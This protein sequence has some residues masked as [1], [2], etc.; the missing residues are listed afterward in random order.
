MHY[1]V[2]TFF[3]SRGVPGIRKLSSDKYKGSFKMLKQSGMGEPSLRARLH[4]R[5]VH[6]W[7]GECF[8][9]DCEK[10]TFFFAS[11]SISE[12]YRRGLTSKSYFIVFA[13]NVFLLNSYID[14]GSFCLP[15][16]SRT[17]H[18]HFAFEIIF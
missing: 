9:D 4:S 12:I 7:A 1:L 5:R 15:L 17:S 6:K 11:L 2:P 3:H 16:L 8:P 14:V 13:F 10:D 18:S